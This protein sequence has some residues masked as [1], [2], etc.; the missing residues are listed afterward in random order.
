M[1]VNDS[2]T[3]WTSPATAVRLQPAHRQPERSQ[4]R[5]CHRCPR[6]SDPRYVRVVVDRCGQLGS[7]LS[8]GWP[9]E[10]RR[11]V[12]YAS[13]S[14][15]AGRSAR[16]AAS[17]SV[18]G[19]RSTSRLGDRTDGRRGWLAVVRRGPRAGMAVALNG[20]AGIRAARAVLALRLFRM[21][22]RRRLSARSAAV[23]GRCQRD[24]RRRLVED[25]GLKI[26]T[27]IPGECHHGVAAGENRVKDHRLVGCVSAGQ[28]R[29]PRCG[30]P[31]H[32]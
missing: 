4:G 26:G 2:A 29:A 3:A 5:C 28:K 7:C 8:T 10:C 6:P 30:I 15:T 9:R 21:A 11:C 24:L 14:G 32:S 12:S 13:S 31:R 1:A 23:T 20:L 25:A 22:A 17:S 16:H 19:R 18:S 27:G